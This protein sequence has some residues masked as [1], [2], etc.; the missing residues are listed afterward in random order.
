MS[1]R[2]QSI[3]GVVQILVDNPTQFYQF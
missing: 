2:A 1:A 3:L